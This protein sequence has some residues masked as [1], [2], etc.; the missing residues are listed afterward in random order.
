MFLENFTNQMH[1]LLPISMSQL[2]DPLSATVEKGCDQEGHHYWHEGHHLHVGGGCTA[3]REA[4]E[5]ARGTI[6]LS[7]DWAAQHQ[8]KEERDYCFHLESK[9]C[10]A[11]F[12]AWQWNYKKLFA[13]QQWLEC[14]LSQGV[15]G[16]ELCW[17]WSG[18]LYIVNL[19]RKHSRHLMH[20]CVHGE[21]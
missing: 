10:T 4:W 17:V 2:F 6:S 12:L 7:Q 15:F 11:G 21:E 8:H 18:L 9:P 5:G 14:I 13:C 3:Q 19:V 20:L 16:G 1:Q